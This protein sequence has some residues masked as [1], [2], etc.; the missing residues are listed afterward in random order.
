MY[1]YVYN[2]PYTRGCP[3]MGCEIN[4]LAT[5]PI[6]GTKGHRHVVVCMVSD[7]GYM[8]IG[9]ICFVYYYVPSPMRHRFSP[10][11]ANRSG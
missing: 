6:R 8:R 10:T 3:V 11:S 7:T 2:H 4:N 1:V 9:G 5:M